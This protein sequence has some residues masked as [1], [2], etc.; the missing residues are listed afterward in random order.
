[1]TDQDGY[2]SAVSGNIQTTTTQTVPNVFDYSVLT[3]S[4]EE[5]QPDGKFTVLRS[6]RRKGICPTLYGVC[7]K[8]SIRAARS[9]KMA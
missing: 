6:F 9:W 3:L 4:L 7:I 1:V 2:S 8:H 5:E